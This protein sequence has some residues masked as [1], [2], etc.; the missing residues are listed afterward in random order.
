MQILH[1]GEVFQRVDGEFKFTHTAVVYR[2]GQDIYHARSMKRYRSP[3]DV[4]MDHLTHKTL[5]PI[6]AYQP[7]FPPHLTRASEPSSASVFI[8]RPRLNGYAFVHHDTGP[9][10]PSIADQV[11]NEVQVYEILKDHPHP[12]IAR[13]L[14]CEVHDGRI[15]GICLPKYLETLSRIVNPGSHGKRALPQGSGRIKNREGILTGIERGIRHLHSLG[16]VHNDI[17]PAN[18]MLEDD[19]AII[20][21]FGSCVR[22]GESL[23]SIARTYEWYDENVQTSCESNDLDALEEI[24]EWM[25]DKDVK[26]FRFKE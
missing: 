14:G 16:L 12:N 21:D 25:S 23:E 13:Y 17:N 18:I 6:T 15:T 11:L 19:T 8:K 26:T 1:E 7:I 3:A 10:P 4:S 20:I 5:I 2:T 24:R 9:E 22:K